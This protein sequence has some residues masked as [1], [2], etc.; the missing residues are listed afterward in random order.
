MNIID[1]E[2]TA[3]QAQLYY[4]IGTVYG[5]IARLE[6]SSDESYIEK[7]LFYFRK[8]I[9]LINADELSDEKYSPYINGFKLSLY[10]NY[11]N[12][13]DHC[14]RKIAA[15]EQYQK[16]L[17]IDGG[18]GMAL[19]NLGMAYRHYAMM[20]SDPVHRDYMNHFA[21]FLSIPIF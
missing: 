4:S 12:A 11:G 20:V 10:T 18:F 5:D 13:F 2:D 17:K 7:Q 15:I 8:S 3:S 1:T 6:K 14:G 9:E 16:A 21:Y 19:G